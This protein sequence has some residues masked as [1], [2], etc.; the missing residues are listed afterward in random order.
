M[1]RKLVQNRH[2]FHIVDNSPWPLIT[3]LNVLFLAV[4]GLVWFHL[5]IGISLFAA[6]LLTT[7][8]AS[9]WFRDV[10]REGTYEGNHTKKV[11]IGLRLG[12][13]LFIIS[14]VMFFFSFFWT[15][16]HSSLAPTVQIGSIWPPLEISVLKTFKVPA[17]NT[18]IL[19]SSGAAV[20]WVHYAIIA[21]KRSQVIQGF[22]V[23][24]FFALLFTAFQF[25]EYLKSKF[26][27]VDGIYGSIFFLI[28][29]FH[30]LHVIIGSI[31]LF[32]CFYRYFDYHFSAKH[33]LGF[34]AAAWYW[35]FVD[36]V[37]ILLF[38]SVYMWGNFFDVNEIENNCSIFSSFDF[39]DSEGLGVKKAFLKDIRIKNK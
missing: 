36:V 29:G 34:Q 3:S 19:I 38:F 32:V 15:F 12:M 23:T 24:L 17:L 11:Q 9:L 5:R 6:F 26:Y 39:I 21:Q 27:M 35:H 4:S 18:L 22:I 13:I 31:F 16:F 28:T 2:F 10:V 1:T 33:H 20:T 30:G 7:F 37:W 25:D 14:E 8:V